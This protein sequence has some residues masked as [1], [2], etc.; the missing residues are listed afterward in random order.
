MKIDNF[1]KNSLL[2]IV[3]ITLLIILVITTYIT[4]VAKNRYKMFNSNSNYISKSKIG[5]RGVF[6][7]RSYKKGEIV[8]VTPCI[9]DNITA[10]N[11]GILKDYIFSHKIPVHVLSFGYG[12][13]YSHNDNPNLSYAIGETDEDLHMTFTA[14]RDINKDEEL[15]ISYGQSWWSSRKD[16][17]TKI[18]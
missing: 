14:K 2:V 13:M 7:G 6:A 16:R 15:F 4:H 12:S 18:D 5:G 1:T 8:E 17:M 3:I 10:F 9:A 11:R